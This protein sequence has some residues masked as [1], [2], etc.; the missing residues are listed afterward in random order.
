MTVHRMPATLAVALAVG[1]ALGVVLGMALG[2]PV[3]HLLDPGP[4]SAAAA[5]TR[6]ARAVGPADRA[7]EAR[8]DTGRE[9]PAAKALQA[10]DRRRATAYATGSAAALR[11]AYVPGSRAGAADLALLRSYLVRGWR[12]VGM[13]TQVLALTVLAHGPRRWRLRV[14]DRLAAAVAVRPGRRVRLPRDRASTHV[15]TLARDADGRWR[16]AAVR[17]G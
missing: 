9:L 3:R 11:A 14:T 10:W 7:V 13:R 12:V 17:P 4:A 1:A 5:P 15:V 2:V 8:D 16:V 6:A